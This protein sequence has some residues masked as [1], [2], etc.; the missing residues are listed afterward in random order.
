MHKI[1]VGR[2]AKSGKF[3]TKVSVKKNPNTTIMQT[4]KRHIARRK[5]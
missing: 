4:V 2:S 3:V 1:T 5:V